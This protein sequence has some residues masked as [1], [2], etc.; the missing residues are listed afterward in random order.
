MPTR[1]RNLGALLSLPLTS[2]QNHDWAAS[3]LFYVF[4]SHLLIIIIFILNPW[5]R[6]WQRTP[7]FF[8]GESHG[9]RSLVGYSPRGRK[10]S[11]TTEWLHFPSFFLSSLMMLFFVKG[12]VKAYLIRY[13]F[14]LIGISLLCFL[15]IF[16]PSILLYHEAW[17][18]STGNSIIQYFFFQS[19]N[20][21]LFIVLY[22]L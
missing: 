9:Q 4:W 8:P 13:T 14:F 16:L 21:C 1:S 10:E 5:R 20:I 19:V 7:V 11:D 2:S 22:L 17:G 3:T 18:L 6:K 15:F 12:S